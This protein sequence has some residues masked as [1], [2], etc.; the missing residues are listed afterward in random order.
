MNDTVWKPEPEAPEGRYLVTRRDGEDGT[1]V[2]HVIVW[3]SGER[4]W[5][6]RYGRTTITHHSFAAPTHWRDVN[7]EEE[8]G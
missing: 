8:E 1:N 6:D 7:E 3:P 4:E 2:C 5:C